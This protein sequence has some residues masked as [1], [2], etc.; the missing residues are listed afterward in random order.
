MDTILIVCGAGASSTFLASRMRSLARGR[1]LELSITAA[2]DTELDDHLAFLDV[3]LVGPHLAPQY[4][5]LSTRATDA[6]AAA[7]LL[8]STAFGPGGAEA[9][10]ESALE[11]LTP[12]ITNEGI[13]HG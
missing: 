10:L 2:S 11:L 7:F 12:P 13:L 6:G 1:G 3:L 8:P 5:A 4:A 9:A